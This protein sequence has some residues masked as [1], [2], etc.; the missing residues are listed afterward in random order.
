MVGRYFLDATECGD[1]LPIAGVEF[2]SGAESREQTGEPHA[3]EEANPLDMQSF[4]YVFAVDYVEGGNFVIDKP[5]QYDFGVNICQASR[6]Y[7][8]Q[9][10]C[11]RCR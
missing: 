1:V 3:L 9:L 11:N 2:V 8:F 6:I 10:V 4:T 5:E 7:H